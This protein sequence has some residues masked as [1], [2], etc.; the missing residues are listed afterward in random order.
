[1]AVR[2]EA[3]VLV[4]GAGAAGMAVAL[5]LVRKGRA[6]EVVDDDLEW[7]GS[8]RALHGTDAKPWAA[9]VAAFGEAVAAAR[10]TVRVR[11]TA[12]GVYGDDVLLVGAAVGGAGAAG[13]VEVVTARTLVLAPGAHDGVLAFEGNDVPGVMSARA[14]GWLLARGVLPGKRI[15]VVRA[16]A[17]GPF[18]E[19]YARAVPGASLEQGTPVAV[20]GSARVREATVASDQGQRTIPC[21]ALLIDAPRAPAYELCAQAGAR[22]ADTSGGAAGFAVTTGPGG[23][24]RPGVFAVGEVTGAPLEPAVVTRD[25][26]T[27]AQ[28]A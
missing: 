27:L 21:D 19:A 6:V 9:L 16:G 5:E 14:A 24:I 1:V 10:V 26:A 12:A 22:L 11:T 28:R 15:L 25:A 23:T 7:G 4:V 3:D 2:R 20:R 8:L 18:G 17:A 13:A